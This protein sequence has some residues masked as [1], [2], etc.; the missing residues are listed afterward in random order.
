MLMFGV[1]LPLGLQPVNSPGSCRRW[2]GLVGDRQ[3]GGGGW[4]CVSSLRSRL[5]L[6]MCHVWSELDGGS[7]L[8]AGC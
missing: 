7:L 8:A 3:G 2:T 1:V 5:P 6:K 4:K